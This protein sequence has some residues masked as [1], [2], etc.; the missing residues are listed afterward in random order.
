MPLIKHV[1]SIEEKRQQEAKPSEATVV[2]FAAAEAK[3]LAD[4]APSAEPETGAKSKGVYT[5]R[6][7][8]KDAEMTKDD[9]WRRREERD[10]ETQRGIRLSGVLQ[11]LLESVNFGQY[12]TGTTAEDYLTKVEEA[13]LRLAKFV[14][15]K[16]Q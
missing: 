3:A 15:E 12:C 11:A 10:I 6:I 1:P 5:G 9:Y 16:A 8:A 2:D 4:M 13:A 14:T 7:K